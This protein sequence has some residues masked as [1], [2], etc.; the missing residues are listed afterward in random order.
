VVFQS[1]FGVVGRCRCTCG[2]VLWL[3][4]WSCEATG[5]TRV[6]ADEGCK[7]YYEKLVDESGLLRQ[8]TDHLQ[9]LFHFFRPHSLQDSSERLAPIMV[10]KEKLLEYEKLLDDHNLVE[11]QKLYGVHLPKAQF[12][13]LLHDKIEKNEKQIALNEELITKKDEIERNEKQIAINEEL[14]AKNEVNQR[15]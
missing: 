13:K 15:R 1:V 10:P 4:N 6:Q 8:V 11:F 2:P 3:K 9:N 7:L 14:I 12:E 5:P